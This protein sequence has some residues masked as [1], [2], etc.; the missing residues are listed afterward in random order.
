MAGAAIDTQR[1]DR[2][3]RQNFIG[4][5]PGVEGALRR[6]ETNRS[7]SRDLYAQLEW[8]QGGFMAFGGARATR[9]AFQSDDRYVVP[10]NP[11]DSGNRRFAATTPVAGLAWTLDAR[12]HLFASAGRGVETPTANELAYRADAQSGLNLAL[13]PARSRQIEAGWRHQSTAR[14][15]DA[16]G[17][18]GSL[19][20]FRADTDQEIAVLSNSG[21]RAT[22]QNAGRT[23]RSGLEASFDWRPAPSLVV[24]AAY[25]TL[26]AR[27]RERFRSCAASP[28]LTPDLVIPAGNRLPGAPQ[29]LGFAALR[30]QVAAPL[31]TTLEWRHQGRMMV[32]DANSDAA[33]A[34]STLAAAVTWRATQGRSAWLV[35][36]RGDNL[37][38]WRGAQTVIVN[39]SNARYFEPRPA[40]SLM[41]S[42]QLTSR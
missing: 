41:L 30:W 11:D 23:R 4:T 2:R 3:G 16:S 9:V 26:E 8:V 29:R 14:Q 28:C 10:G 20:W 25:T 1:E 42:V 40:R 19:V 33:D 18:Q 21:G 32:D 13:Q 5:Q 34:A 15:P 24:H 22:F 17:W 36:L 12:N 6:D 39:E 27:Y 38:N 37:T 7:R 35:T 31:S